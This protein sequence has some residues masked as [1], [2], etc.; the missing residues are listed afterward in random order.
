[1]YECC[2]IQGKCSHVECGEWQHPHYSYECT[3]LRGQLGPVPTE[4]DYCAGGGHAFHHY[5]NEIGFCFCGEQEY[6]LCERCDLAYQLNLLWEDGCYCKECYSALFCSVE[7]FSS[8]VCDIGTKGCEVKH[9]GG[10]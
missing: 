5:D 1:M 9:Y 4:E 8:M 3:S 2:Y 7:L 6:A 10:K